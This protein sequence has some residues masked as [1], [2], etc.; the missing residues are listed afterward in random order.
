[1]DNKCACR[2]LYIHVLILKVYADYSYVKQSVEN[3]SHG[4]IKFETQI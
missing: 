3:V 4:P 1:M 2:Y